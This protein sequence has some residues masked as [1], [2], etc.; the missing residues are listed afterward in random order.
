VYSSVDSI[1][2]R[3][4]DVDR[5]I[6]KITTKETRSFSLFGFTIWSTVI[7]RV[8]MLTMILF[9]LS[10]SGVIL[11][12]RTGNS[13]NSAE[14]TKIAIALA[15]VRAEATAEAVARA[16]V[17]VETGTVQVLT[18]TPDPNI[19][20]LDTIS[21]RSFAFAGGSDPQFQGEANLSV[22]YDNG[23]RKYILDYSL[24]DDGYTW[25]G[26]AIYYEKPVNFSSYLTL[27]VDI[28]DLDKATGFQ[29]KVADESGNQTYL[30]VT[31]PPKSET[32]IYIEIIGDD[33]SFKI[34]LRGNFDNINLEQV[35]EVSFI[36][37]SELVKGR[38]S[39]E[40]GNIRLRK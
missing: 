1:D 28:Q 6:S 34:P 11:S 17:Q 39:M 19:L 10:L 36:V 2:T 16:T 12:Y 21:S 29:V 30:D 38:G 31:I 27:D 40:I 20:P 14:A 25:A 7:E 8:T 33:R 37:N 26:Y 13:T 24:P 22:K 9:I 3:L 4:S 18:P 32:R 35:K 5:A 15:T 23:M